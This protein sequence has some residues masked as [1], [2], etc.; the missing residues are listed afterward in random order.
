MNLLEYEGV[1]ETFSFDITVKLWPNLAKQ[2]GFFLKLS[3]SAH[4]VR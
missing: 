4:P 1:P 2:L 3:C